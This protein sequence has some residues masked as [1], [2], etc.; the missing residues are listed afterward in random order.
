MKESIRYSIDLEE[1][2]DSFWAHCS[3]NLLIREEHLLAIVYARNQLSTYMGQIVNVTAKT[4]I[5][6]FMKKFVY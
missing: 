6:E 1:Y 4:D 2:F 3:N 5:E